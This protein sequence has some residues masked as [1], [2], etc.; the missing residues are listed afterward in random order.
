MRMTSKERTAYNRGLRH[1]LT[2]IEAEQA[3]T[4]PTWDDPAEK[5]KVA[6]LKACADRIRALMK[7]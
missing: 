1:A 5:A 7:G 4:D 3:A 2:Q 6:A